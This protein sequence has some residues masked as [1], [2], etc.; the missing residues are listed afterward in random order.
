MH[1]CRAVVAWLASGAIALSART[2]DARAQNV[3]PD[4]WHYTITPYAWLPA[5]QGKVGVG[6]VSSNVDLS[7]GEMMRAMNFGIMGSAE[8][9]KG[10]LLIGADGVYTSL[11]QSQAFAVRGD[12]GRLE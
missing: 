10:S 3:P 5:M 11:G 6:T 1:G 8:A 7:A 4:K 9:R 12:T 2:N